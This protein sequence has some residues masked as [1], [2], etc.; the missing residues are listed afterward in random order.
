MTNERELLSVLTKVFPKESWDEDSGASMSRL[1]SLSHDD[2]INLFSKQ[3]TLHNEFSLLNRSCEN[4]QEI[5]IDSDILEVDINDYLNDDQFK[6]Y[7]KTFHLSSAELSEKIIRILYKLLEAQKEIPSID[8]SYLTINCLN[9][10][11]DTLTRLNE[12]QIFNDNDQTVIKIKITD[13]ICQ[14]FN[15]L[16]QR[17]DNIMKVHLRKIYSILESSVCESEISYGLLMCI[18]TTVANL[19]K[20]KSSQR[21]ENV[22]ILK[23][24]NHLVLK[25]ME[26]L[27]KNNTKFLFM[28]QKRLMEIMALLRNTQ[29]P[30]LIAGGNGMKKKRR[31]KFKYSSHHHSLLDSCIFEKL[32]IHSFPFIR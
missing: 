7:H 21:N 29:K 30:S 3:F 26:M 32:L 13:L 20:Q 14:C 8:Q 23:L 11:F 6:A 4:A 24:C 18:F 25:H 9:F 15:S 31:R 28:I 1:S 12:K 10:C 5:L 27:S 2:V 16:V 22:E 17:V 19:C